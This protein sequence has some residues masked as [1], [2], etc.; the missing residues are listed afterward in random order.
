[1]RWKIVIGAGRQ[2]SQGRQGGPYNK[3][4]TLHPSAAPRDDKTG[5]ALNPGA[6]PTTDSRYL[7][8]WHLVSQSP[9]PPFHNSPFTI[10]PSPLPN[11][12]VIR[13][14]HVEEIRLFT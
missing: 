12:S 5:G 8:T 4:A 11:H 10:P 13:L 9:I 1:M 6:H 7:I 14:I 2:D 3:I